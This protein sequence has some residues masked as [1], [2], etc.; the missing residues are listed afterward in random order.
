MLTRSEFVTWLAA[1]RAAG[2]PLAVI[3][4]SMG[5]S[6]QAVRKWLAGR[7]PSQ[8]ALMLAEHLCRAPLEMAPGLTVAAERGRPS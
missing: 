6:H 2:E 8:M 1:R 3:G 7:E 5:V 4:S